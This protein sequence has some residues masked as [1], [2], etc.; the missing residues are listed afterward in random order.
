MPK[1]NH[2]RTAKFPQM[3]CEKNAFVVVYIYCISAVCYD[4]LIAEL[5][6][7]ASIQT[8]MNIYVHVT[9]DSMTRAIRLFENRYNSVG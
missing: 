6:G 9:D 4:S 3:T 8:T 2:T 5:L 7:H 1:E